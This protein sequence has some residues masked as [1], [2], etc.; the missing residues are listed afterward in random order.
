M[1]PV[2]DPS[3]ARNS[4][5]FK[6]MAQE[7]SAM[8]P[9]SYLKWH[10]SNVNLPVGWNQLMILI[11]LPHMHWEDPNFTPEIKLHEVVHVCMY[12]RRK[13][14]CNRHGLP[15]RTKSGMKTLQHSI[16]LQRRWRSSSYLQSMEASS[17][18]RFACVCLLSS[19]GTCFS[20]VQFPRMRDL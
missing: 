15:E 19:R 12:V 20:R 18:L 1:L 4:D 16:A 8:H 3:Q 13:L 10:I 14:Q 17:S 9:I 5:P 7:N 11:T 2:I 6:I